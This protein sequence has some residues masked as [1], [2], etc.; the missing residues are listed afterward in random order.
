LLNIGTIALESLVFAGIGKLLSVGFQAIKAAYIAAQTGSRAAAKLQL[1]ELARIQRL[2]ATADIK[3]LSN[4]L[5]AAGK[6]GPP[7]PP[8]GL[9]AGMMDAWERYGRLYGHPL[10]RE[11]FVARYWDSAA[12]SLPHNPHGNWRYPP[13]GGVEPGTVATAHQPTTGEIWDR[14]GGPWGRFVSPVRRDPATGTLLAPY[15]YRARSLPPESVGPP[16]Y[17]QYRWIRDWTDA[18]ETLY[19]TIKLGRTAA[20]FGQPGGALQLESPQSIEWLLANNYIVLVT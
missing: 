5:E 10:T 12:V 6:L 9:P 11:E 8:P 16:G 2:A 4:T 1:T 17:F 20:W 18:D 3:A 7:A 13:N 15:P 19:G 14:W